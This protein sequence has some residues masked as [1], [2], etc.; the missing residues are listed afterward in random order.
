MN[1]QYYDA[2]LNI[3]TVGEQKGFNKSL[4]YHRYEP[5]PY[6]ALET[7]FNQYE[8][9][10]SERVVDFGCGKGR[11]NFYIHHACGAS[12]VGIEMNEMFYKEA[13]E[14]LERYAKKSRNSKDKIQFQCCLAQEYEIDPRDNRFYFFNPFSVQVFMNVINNIL[15][16]VEEVE[17]EIEIIL[18]YPSEDYI[19]FLENQ[20][21]FELKEEIRLP[22]VY[23]RNGNERFLVYGLRS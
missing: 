15:L 19:F 3:K 4:H 12:A 5:T 14:N 2:V 20:T 13:M 16:S 7:L 6:S 1:E 21:A 18:Y 17:R 8:L 11:L 9:S 23:E 22:G 10:S